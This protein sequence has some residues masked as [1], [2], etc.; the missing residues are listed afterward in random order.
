MLKECPHSVYASH[1]Y[2]PWLTIVHAGTPQRRPPPAAALAQAVKHDAVFTLI[3]T[4]GELLT[5]ARKL[6]TFQLT[7]EHAKVD[8]PAVVGEE[9]ADGITAAVVDNVIGDDG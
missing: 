7:L 4:L 6:L 3:D 5:Q 8:A 2:H 9:R 1:D